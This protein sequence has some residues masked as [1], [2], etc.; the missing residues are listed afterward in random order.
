MRRLLLSLYFSCLIVS[1]S[2]QDAP[3]V[4]KYSMGDLSGFDD[5]E[6]IRELYR[7]SSEVAFSVF[8][9]GNKICVTHPRKNNRY[10]VDLLDLDTRQV[11]KRLI[12]FESDGQEWLSPIASMYG[13]S[14]I[15]RDNV[16]NRLAIIDVAK[17]ACQNGYLP[18]LREVDFFSTR[19]IPMGKKL[20]FWNPYGHDPKY[21]RVLVT[22]EDG[23][24]DYPPSTPNMDAFNVDHGDLLYNRERDIAVLAHAREPVIEFMH[25]DGIVYKKLEFDHPATEIAELNLNGRQM[26][27]YKGPFVSCFPSA[28]GRKDIFAAAFAQA[29]K[30]DKI[31]L[32]DWDGNL[33]S[34]FRVKGD[35]I[36]SISLSSDGKKVYSWEK[37]GNHHVLREY[38]N[39]TSG[40]PMNTESFQQ[41]KGEVKADSLFRSSVPVLDE[42]SRSF[43]YVVNSECSACIKKALDSYKSYLGSFP[44]D[45]FMFLSKS[46]YLDLFLF[47]ANRD[48]VELPPIFSSEAIGD[49]NEGLYILNG[50]TVTGFPS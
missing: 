3:Q 18:E 36:H 13:D 25:S 49:L 43:V 12:D 34:G 5:N 24:Y 11:I 23:K 31:L 39:M 47:Y 32:F 4:V 30:E 42:R 28:S 6:P 37:D 27:V 7:D 50:G 8:V 35:L 10:A 33:I 26:F 1:C 22:D 2:G 14:L 29:D 48:L 45:R 9:S 41:F 15:I 44:Q 46:D 38:L 20:I 21:P 16:V 40:W 17:A 19:F